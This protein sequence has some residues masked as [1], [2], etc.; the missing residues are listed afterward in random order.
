LERT[1]KAQLHVRIHPETKHWLNIYAGTEGIEIGELIEQLLE[2]RRL[3]VEGGDDDSAETL[4]KRLSRVNESYCKLVTSET[5]RLRRIGGKLAFHDYPELKSEM[6]KIQILAL[7]EYSSRK[8]EWDDFAKKQEAEGLR[9]GSV[10]R[11][12]II[13]ATELCARIKQLKDE[14][15]A[16]QS[17]LRSRYGLPEVKQVPTLEDVSPKIE[18]PPV[19]L[20]REPS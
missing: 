19:T 6:K 1:E 8:Q 15:A 20:E 3:K 2:E 17:K 18:K 4:E 11:L 7:D 10:S 13:K 5:Q 16:L 12:D 9:V 14:Q